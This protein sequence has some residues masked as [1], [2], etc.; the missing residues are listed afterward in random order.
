M[1]ICSEGEEGPKNIRGLVRG[2]NQH[3]GK[4][5]VKEKVYDKVKNKIFIM[6]A[7]ATGA[8]RERVSV[9]EMNKVRKSD[10]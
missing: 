8:L 1:I 7:V 6:N 3:I 9:V 5:K 2:F 10:S 4:R